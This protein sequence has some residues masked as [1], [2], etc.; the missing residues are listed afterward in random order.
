MKTIHLE[1]DGG[2]YDITVGKGILNRAGELFNLDRKVLIVTDSGVPE[3]YAKTV[4]SSAKDS[5]I[6][7]VN[8][9]EGSKSLQT[10]SYVCEKM[11]EFGMTRT[12]CVVAVGGGVVGD[13]AGF[14]A[15]SYMRGIDFYNI[16][17]TTLSQIDSSIGGKTAV[18]HCG[19]KNI[20]GVFHQPKGVLIDI[21]V[22][23][24]LPKRQIA[25]GLAEAVKMAMTFDGELFE[26]I[27]QQDIDN[28][29]PE[30]II[31]GALNI[32]KRVVELD[33]KEN[34]LRR[35]LNFGHTFGH[36]IE[37][38]EELN[39]L[40]HGECV[41]LGMTYMCEGEVKARLIS[42]L[43]R[44]GLPTKYTGDVNKALGFISHDKKCDGKFVTC[45]FVDRIGSY[46]FE[47]M[48]QED[49][50]RHISSQG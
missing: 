30:D 6:V 44:L 22:Q 7:T 1:L 27:E 3:I 10:Y 5:L 42:L 48:T 24:T 13:L 49:F 19:V 43:S 25:S 32:K 34:G 28:F 4:A 33:E 15:G 9:G 29:V 8:E 41:A 39:G 12:D 17:T 35:V 21:N 36:A 14:V 2:G 11:L 20:L 38:E 50:T 26:L 37:A 45:V 46:R 18:N 31:I 16:P 47:K 40:Y 23:L